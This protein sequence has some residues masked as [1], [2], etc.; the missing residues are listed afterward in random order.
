MGIGLLFVGHSRAYIRSPV[1][2]FKL[3]EKR[4]VC[5]LL[6]LEWFCRCKWL[7]PLVSW[8]GELWVS[9]PGVQ[10]GVVVEVL[11]STINIVVG[12]RNFRAVNRKLN[13]RLK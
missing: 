13:V 12:F 4:L 9:E 6:R 11:F 7:L 2:S 5:P 8:L 1:L 3:H 10:S